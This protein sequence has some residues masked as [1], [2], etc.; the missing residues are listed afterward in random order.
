MDLALG[1]FMSSLKRQTAAQKL[2]SLAGI[3][4]GKA[5]VEEVVPPMV[6]AAP[7]VNRKRGHPP[8]THVGAEVGP[9]SIRV[10]FVMQFELR[11]E[12]EGVLAAISTKHLIEKLV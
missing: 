1:K 4:K 3:E 5:N 9:S 12:D 10:A 11:P 6:V 2:S 8:K 7:A